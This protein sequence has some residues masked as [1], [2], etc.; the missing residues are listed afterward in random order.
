MANVDL[1]SLFTSE[2]QYTVLQLLKVLIDTT[3][4]SII[5]NATLTQDVDK[6]LLTLVITS[7]DDS[8]I[9]AST[10]LNSLTSDEKTLIS[11]LV[12]NIIAT[13]EGMSFL[14]VVNF[15][16]NEVHKGSEIH[17]GY[18]SFLGDENHTGTETHKGIIKTNEIDNLNGNAILR[19]KDTENK[20]VVG[21]SEKPAMIMGS[22]DRPYYSKDGSDFTGEEL[23]LKSDVSTLYYHNI[24]I[25]NGSIASGR[26][27]VCYFTIISNRAE[28]YDMSSILSYYSHLGGYSVPVTGWYYS[29]EQYMPIYA[30]ESY[31]STSYF[32]IKYI[33]TSNAIKSFTPTFSTLIIRSYTPKKIS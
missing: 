30:M 33:D 16:G 24:E 32:N 17:N 7:N 8:T 18:A 13:D 22:T 29:D 5:K 31:P 2:N 6:G 1:K 12:T 4:E 11:K 15:E 19:Y 25:A 10:A 20:V 23:A 21:T 26:T 14:K 27:M 9:A 3:E 28:A